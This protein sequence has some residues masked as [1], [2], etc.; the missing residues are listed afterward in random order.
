MH[1]DIAGR[2][3]AYEQAFR[4]YGIDVTR[5]DPSEGGA[6]IR[7][8]SIRVELAAA[9]DDWALVCR[10]TRKKE[11]STWKDLLAAARVADP[12]DWRNQ[13]RDA[14]EREN[15]RRWRAWR[16]RSGPWSYR[17]PPWFSSAKPFGKRAGPSRRPPCF[18][19]RG[20]GIRPTSGSTTIWRPLLRSCGR[21]GDE[22]IRFFTAAVALR[23]HDAVAHN[24]L[25]NALLAKGRL[26][27]A[28]AEYRKVDTRHY[29]SLG[30]VLLKKGRLDEAIA[31]YRQAL[32]INKDDAAAHNG[33]GCACCKRAG[34]TSALPSTTRPSA[35]TRMVVLPLTTHNLGNALLAF[36][37]PLESFEAQRQPAQLVFAIWISAGDVADQVR[38]ELAQAGTDG[39]VQPGQVVVV[40][41]PIGQI[42]VNRGMRLPT[43][44]SYCA[45]GG[46][47]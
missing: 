10:R 36:I 25:G 35:S 9:L 8:R 40:A 6:R 7:A 43:P 45:G 33:L 23:P 32:R 17:L 37:S 5:L 22:A 44:D 14:L 26:D 18:A 31:T 13:V 11:D 42:D 3:P 2:D 19:K 1:F 20:C 16:L 24:N 38:L 4:E 15:Q 46:R 47:W 39:V 12:D 29:N 21:R 28:M 34:W 30:G 41:N 27:E